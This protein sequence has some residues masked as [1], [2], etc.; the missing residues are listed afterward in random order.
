MPMA[1]SRTPYRVS[2]FGGGT[3]YPA[4]F[5]QHGG[6]VL[7]MTINKYCYISVRVLPPFFAGVRHRIVWSHIENAERLANIAHP[8]VRAGMQMLGFD[9][10]EG[11][12]L[13]HQGDVP[14]RSGIGSSSSFSVGLINAL[15]ALRGRYLTPRELA[16]TAMELEQQRLKESVGCQDQIA[17]AYGGLNTIRFNRDGRYDVT[18]LEL[19]EP[20][21]RGFESWLLLFYTGSSRL[22][23]EYAKKLVSNI[24]AN[25][26]HLTRMGAMVPVARNL[27][28]AGKFDE[29]GRLLDENWNLKR[30]LTN[31]T[32]NSEVDE[33]Y[34][35]ALGAGALGGKL[36]GAG[37]TGFMVFVVPPEKQKNVTQAL[38]QLIQVP[39]TTDFDGSTIIYQT[40]Q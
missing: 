12:E 14:A 3:D 29:F 37:G 17:S 16:D 23:E 32:S 34:A 19:P 18:P 21:R 40:E 2:F 1:I 33:V 7:S 26:D 35:R 28:T 6:A 9:D 5:R 4:W 38:S 25:T 30:G 22:S 24:D 15:H 8:A 36:L 10:K 31:G 39:I 27:L 20:R 11:I 13:H